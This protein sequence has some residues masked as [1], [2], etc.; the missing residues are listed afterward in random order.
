VGILVGLFILI[1]LLRIDGGLGALEADGFLLGFRVGDLEGLLVPDILLYLVGLE[2]FGLADLT[3]G[4]VV[5]VVVVELGLRVRPPAA[6][7]FV[8]DGAAVRAA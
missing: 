7:S 8:N 1:V 6:A 4:R 5:V 3:D 2:V